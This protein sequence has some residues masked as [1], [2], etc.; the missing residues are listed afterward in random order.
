[1]KIRRTA[2]FLKDYQGLPADIQKRIDKQI[3]FLVENIRHPS[4]NMKKLRG[5]D[6]LEVRVTKGYRMTL[7]SQEDFIELRRVGTHDILRKES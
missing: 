3:I 6:K 4:L 5:T 7:R 1:M 2:S